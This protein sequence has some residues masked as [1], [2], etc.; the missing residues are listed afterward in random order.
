MSANSIINTMKQIASGWNALYTF[1]AV[2]H[3]GYVIDN[4][5]KQQLLT[6]EVIAGW[7]CDNFEDFSKGIKPIKRL[8]EKQ[9]RIP[10][11]PYYAEHKNEKCDKKSNRLEEHYA[12]KLFEI[13]NNGKGDKPNWPF[14]NVIDYQVPLK[15]G[16]RDF[17]GKI[18]LL[19]YND[20]KDNGGV[21]IIELKKPGSKETLLRCILEAFTYYKTIADKKAFLAS[22][23]H[24]GKQLPANTPFW[25]CP[26]FFAD[27]Q[28]DEDLKLKHDNLSDLAKKIGEEVS[29]KL[30]RITKKGDDP[31]EWTFESVA[32]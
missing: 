11:K 31:R 2:N 6:K 7:L 10:N 13:C 18:D 28:P 14:G 27:S 25:I 22:F 20:D 17:A 30:I 29:I 16:Q 1:S 24:L 3:N 26:M 12:K 21:Y 23:S 32:L 5:T 15:N 9:G 4:D 19:S 8:G